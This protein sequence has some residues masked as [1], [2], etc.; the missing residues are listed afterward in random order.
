LQLI[1]RDVATALVGIWPCCLLKFDLLTREHL[2]YGVM[3]V[4]RVYRHPY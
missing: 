2:R 3:Q 1:S 4:R